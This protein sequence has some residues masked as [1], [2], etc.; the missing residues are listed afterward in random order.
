MRFLGGWSEL[1][2]RGKNTNGEGDVLEI[3]G[4]DRESQVKSKKE[5]KG[6]LPK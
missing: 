6:R 2:T 3:G 5:E 4:D 1:R